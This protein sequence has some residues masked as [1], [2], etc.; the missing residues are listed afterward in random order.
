[1]SEFY[2][3]D[4]V[5]GS[6]KTSAAINH[7][8][9]SEGRFIFL[10]PY[11]DECRR[12]I[13]GCP[14]KRFVSP[15]EKPTSKVVHLNDL[16]REGRNIA[17]TH[18]LFANYTPETVQLII[19]GGYTL[20]MDEVFAVIQRLKISSSDMKQLVRD[21]YIEVDGETYR[22]KWID[23]S[24]MGSVGRE[25][26][27]RAQSGTVYYY[28]NSM[29][30]WVC[31]FK[32]FAAFKDVIILTFMFAAQLQ[33]YY[34]DT[35]GVDYKYIGVKKTSDTDYI[36]TDVPHNNISM[37]GGILDKISVI[38]NKKYNSVGDDYYSLSSGWYKKAEKE[39]GKISLVK[40]RNTIRSALQRRLSGHSDEIMWTTFDRQHRHVENKGLSK[41]YVT[42]TTR[43]TNKHRERDRLAY[44]VNIFFNPYVMRY[45]QDRG[46]EIDDEAYAL[47]EMIQW[48]WRSAIR[49]GKHI[50]IYIPSSRMRNLLVRWL[51]EVDGRGTVQG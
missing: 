26:K 45:F 25:L 21:K 41:A 11:L 16:L 12:I 1:M 43:A 13:D 6:G 30:L 42:C 20:I 8:N 51:N 47:S 10:S 17:S 34:F 28:N 22:V 39:T 24:Y 3:C 31:P 44:C 29:A 2:I 23:D 14:S 32:L 49:D 5:M 48:I 35:H 19:D 50:W 37:L 40:L 36:F 33:R 15:I 46:C 4:S 18:A 38:D 9:T 27:L 7:M